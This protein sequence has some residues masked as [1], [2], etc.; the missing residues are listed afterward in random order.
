MTV[1]QLY[2]EK[3]ELLVWSLLSVLQSK[4]R[5]RALLTK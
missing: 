3:A 5:F 2:I 1:H 4:R